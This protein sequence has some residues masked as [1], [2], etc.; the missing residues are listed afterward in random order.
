MAW[1]RM[2][3]RVFGLALAL[4]L[5]L[6][7]W[8]E[9]AEKVVRCGPWSVDG[10]EYG[11]RVSVRYDD[12]QLTWSDG[13]IRMRADE[14]DRTRQGRIYVATGEVYFAYS[15]RFALGNKVAFEPV[16][17]VLIRQSVTEVTPITL[18]CETPK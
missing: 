5:P 15:D 12:R 13:H 18:H 10:E 11:A 17:I 1:G 14:V 7:T 2:S 3:R 9:A 6:A 4:I 16:K 8:S